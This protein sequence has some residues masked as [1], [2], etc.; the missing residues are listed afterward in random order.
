MNQYFAKVDD[1][2]TYSS[3]EAKALSRI[4]GYMALTASEFHVTCDIKAGTPPALSNWVGIRTT[5]ALRI[6]SSVMTGK[7][8][9]VGPAGNETL[10]AI[11]CED[12]QLTQQAANQERAMV[13]QGDFICAI[14]APGVSVSDQ[15][16]I[17]RVVPLLGG[18]TAVFGT[19][20]QTAENGV[21]QTP[22]STA[23]AYT[24]FGPLVTIAGLAGGANPALPVVPPAPVAP[25]PVS[26]G[27]VTYIGGMSR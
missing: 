17:E 1:P 26:P 18:G 20:S 11:T 23:Q 12:N 7:V 14:C 8:V 25:V 21:Y 9:Q 4:L 16:I 22:F 24:N 15:L 19:A 10:V 27:P 13:N 2:S 3:S 5:N 6:P